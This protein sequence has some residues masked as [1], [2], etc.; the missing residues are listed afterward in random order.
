[1]IPYNTMPFFWKLVETVL[2]VLSIA[3]C[4]LLVRRARR[5]AVNR[6]TR[7]HLWW[8][9]LSQWVI[10]A[11]DCIAVVYSIARFV[12]LFVDF[13]FLPDKHFFLVLDL[14]GI[15]PILG[16]MFGC[17]LVIELLALTRIR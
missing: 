7:T 14:L 8:T 13:Q 4:C 16:I 10:W 6:A 12:V 17:A 15:I 9:A 1:M 5:R 3:I 11:M 2:V